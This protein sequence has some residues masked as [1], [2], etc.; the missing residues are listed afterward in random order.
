MRNLR[1]ETSKSEISKS[2]KVYFYDNGIRNS[3]IQNFNPL[4]IRNDQG[5]LWENFCISERY[6]YNIAH[7]KK[8]NIF[9]W[10]TYDQKEI[11][12][13]EEFSGK[14]EAYEFKWTENSAKTPSDFTESYKVRASVV[15]KDNFQGFLGD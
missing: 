11:D 8:P 5:A 1:P 10:R 14:F 13:I 9:F 3:L 7:N 4:A 15:N 6:K 2:V 12:Y